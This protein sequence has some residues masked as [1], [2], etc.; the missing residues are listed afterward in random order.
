[1]EFYPLRFK[2]EAN[3][4]IYPDVLFMV[5][6]L[7][8][9]APQKR[10]LLS[11][12]Y[13]SLPDALGGAW[14]LT[15]EVNK[16]LV[17]RGW[18][19]HL[20][21]CKPDDTLLDYELI[22]GVHF[23]RIRQR[24]SKNVVSLWRAIKKLINFICRQTSLSLVHIHNP[25]VGFLALLSPRLRRI[26]KVTHFHSSWLDEEKIN[27]QAQKPTGGAAGIFFSLKLACILRVI[28][29]MEGRCFKD[30][31]SIL[32]LSEYSRKHFLR[33]YP[34]RKARLRVIPGGVD[35]NT[36]FPLEPDQ[37]RSALR[38]ALK[39]PT[40][41]PV[42]LTVRRLE[43]RMGLDNLILAA[44]QIVERA[45]ELD[46]LI[47]IGGKGA[48]RE[49]LQALIQQNDLE[50]R[51]RLVG[52]ITREHLP[53][54]YRSADVFIL[55]TLS[56]EGFGL[57]TVEALASGLPVLGTPVGG[58]VEILKG[59]DENLL[60]PGT[61]PEALSHRIEKFL[62]NPKPFEAL[63]TRCRERAL[64]YY[65]WEK[66]LDLIEDEFSLVLGK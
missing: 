18:E 24:D 16:R 7:M 59:I 23:H 22:E 21:T 35:V 13:H 10:C 58:T 29:F 50:D 6:S 26:P 62:R 17:A 27:R 25:L 60:F 46:F 31:R 57:V 9:H 5:T 42:L 63:K 49:K 64:Q 43:A 66:V 65:S 37:D 36:F 34:K 40:D 32:F 8:D 52:V 28:K 4:L 33:Y 45:P 48:L 19:V 61:T 44:G 20:I 51:V 2:H 11:L 12:Q 38:E 47:V 30:S 56:I 1:M 3:G 14:G 54:Y 39:L 41:R 15:H 53:H 55:P